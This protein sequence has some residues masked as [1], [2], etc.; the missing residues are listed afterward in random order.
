MSGTEEKTATRTSAE[1]FL[2]II[3]TIDIVYSLPNDSERKGR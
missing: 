3:P 2:I 1:R